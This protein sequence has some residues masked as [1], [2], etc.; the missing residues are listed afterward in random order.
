M[1]HLLGKAA[2]KGDI[3]ALGRLLDAGADIEWMHKGTGRTPLL[4]AT[5]AGHEDAVRYLLDR[6]ADID[7]QCKAMGYTALAWAASK[8]LD[9]IVGLLIARGAMLDLASPKLLRTALMCAAMAGYETSV[10]LLLDA[11]ADA[12][13]IDFREENALSL[14]KRNGHMSVVA[15]LERDGAQEPP[16]PAPVAVLPWPTLD[17]DKSVTDDPAGVVRAYILAMESWELKGAA[18]R[19]SG[20]GP[21]FWDE[22]LAIVD[23]HCTQRPRAYKHSSFSS[24]PDYSARDLLLSVTQASASKVDV[25]VL[26]DRLSQNNERLFVVRRKHGEWRIDSLKRRMRGTQDWTNTIL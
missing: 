5:I 8:D 2:E 10:S 19:D 11:G 22:Q 3:A 20:L 1:S 24:P 6:G 23:R 7:H 18:L 26:A 12:S 9:A 4:E 16:K 21:D 17:P 14:A 25:M 13:P 15:R